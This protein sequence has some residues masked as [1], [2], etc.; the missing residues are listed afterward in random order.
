MAIDNHLLGLRE[1]AREHFKE[2]PEIF[3]DETYL[4]SNRFILSTSQVGASCSL[5]LPSKAQFI[6]VLPDL[7]AHSKNNVKKAS[8]QK[9]YH[10]EVCKLLHIFNPVLVHQHSKYWMQL[11]LQRQHSKVLCR[12]SGN[13]HKQTS[14]IDMRA[15]FP[16]YIYSHS[17]S[18]PPSPKMTCLGSSLYSTDSSHK[19]EGLPLWETKSQEPRGNFTLKSC[20]I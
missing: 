4:T 2:L 3:T 5:V 6:C 20:Y 19:P 1:V 14:K 7:V 12:N 13:A 8:K 17:P 10:Q 15:Q 11:S 9:Q 16:N 18:F